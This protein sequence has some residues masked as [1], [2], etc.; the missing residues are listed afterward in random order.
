MFGVIA[1]ASSKI[2]T[3]DEIKARAQEA[4]K[5]LPPNRFSFSFGF[6]YFFLFSFFLFLL[7]SFIF[8]ILFFF[9]FFCW[10][11]H[12]F[13]N[14]FL[15]F[16]FQTYFVARLWFGDDAKRNGTCKIKKFSWMCKR[17]ESNGLKKYFST[18]KNWKKK[19]WISSKTLSLFFFVSFSFC[20]FF[21]FSKSLKFFMRVCFRLDQ[22]SGQKEYNYSIWFL[23][24]F[25]FIF[26]L[27]WDLGNSVPVD[28]KNFKKKKRKKKETF[29]FFFPLQKNKIKE[30]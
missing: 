12:S 26:W 8:L 9:L 25:V 22:K 3:K 11:S 4:L 20:F 5:Y 21:L 7:Y 24:L 10:I 15:I 16:I 29:G 6:S 30:I 17:T 14:W 23:Y 28:E 1:I 19:K 18:P 2:E 13:L 27:V